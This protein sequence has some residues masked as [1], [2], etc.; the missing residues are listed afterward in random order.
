MA[1][2]QNTMRTSTGNNEANQSHVNH[3]E[4]VFNVQLPYDPHAPTE[5]DFWSGSFHS[6]SLHGSMEHFASDSKSIKDS[7]NFMS[8]YIAVKQV[9]GKDVNDFTDFDGMGN[10][11]W[12]FILL[13]YE[14]KWDILNTDNKTNT[15]RTKILSKFTI[16]TKPNN[17]NRKELAKMVPMSIK[18]SPPVLNPPLPAKLKSEVNTISKYFKGKKP[19]SN[20][21]KPSKSYAQA[22]KPMASTS[23]VLKIKES[24]PALTAKQIDR[25]NNIV[26]GNPTPKLR[27]Q[28]TT[29]EPSRKQVIVPMSTDNNTT[30]TKN[31]ALHM[32][33]INRLLKNAKLDIA[34]DF[35]RSNPNSPVIVTNKITNQSDLQIISQYI[36]RSEDINKLQVKEP[37]LPQSKSYLKIIKIPFFPNGRSQD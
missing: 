36:R 28:M 19:T 34:A 24:F 9:N 33:N 23:D 12:N 30:F 31:S 13:V 14:A 1:D 8:K 10:A 35:I 27:I 2:P 4:S 6:I 26:K 7:L 20:Q 11:I 18:K 37:R 29:K 15:L 22:S 16:R 25:V 21:S 17:N 5:P 32:A 3:E